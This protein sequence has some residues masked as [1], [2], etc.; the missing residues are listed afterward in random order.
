MIETN[1][2]FGIFADICPSASISFDFLFLE[3]SLSIFSFSCSTSPTPKCVI[4]S[5]LFSNFLPSLSVSSVK[6]FDI[7]NIVHLSLESLFW[8]GLPFEKNNQNIRFLEVQLLTVVFSIYS[9]PIF[10]TFKYPISLN[11]QKSLSSNIKQK[12]I[13]MF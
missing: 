12:Y 6:S 3:E 2:Q 7:F 1:Q 5:F 4:C 10:N 9:Y 13:S 8:S 11:F